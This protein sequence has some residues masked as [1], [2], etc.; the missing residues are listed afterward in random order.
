MAW[1]RPLLSKL[2]K[3]ILAGALV[4]LIQKVSTRRRRRRSSLIIA[5]N[6]LERHAHTLS[7]DAGADLR[8]QAGGGGGERL[9][10]D[11]KRKANSLSRGT[12]QASALGL[13]G[14]PPPHENCSAR[15]D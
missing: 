12:R 5:R 3:K 2:V 8:S 14:R 9:I 7:G 15:Y 6:D 11:L 10:K 13:E 1:T 4:E